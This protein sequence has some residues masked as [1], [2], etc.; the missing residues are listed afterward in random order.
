[1]P[2]TN[3]DPELAAWGFFLQ[4]KRQAGALETKALA[5]C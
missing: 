2:D 4:K 3:K 1:L 5:I